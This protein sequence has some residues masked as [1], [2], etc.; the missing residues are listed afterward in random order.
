[1]D[2]IPNCIFLI[3]KCNFQCTMGSASLEALVAGPRPRGVA[4]LSSSAHLEPRKV[5]SIHKLKERQPWKGLPC[6]V[7]GSGSRTRHT[8]ISSSKYSTLGK[9]SLA[10]S[11]PSG[12]SRCRRYLGQPP[13]FGRLSKP[14]ECSVIAQ[15]Q[16]RPGRLSNL[17]KVWYN[18]STHHNLRIGPEPNTNSPLVKWV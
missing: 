1:M 6:H 10:G 2:G 15:G 13:Y 3:R 17:C 18:Q 9:E 12:H 11:L 4:E 16:A 8:R 14:I 7:F 5:V